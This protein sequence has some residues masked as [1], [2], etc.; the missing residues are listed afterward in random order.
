VPAD[1]LP[2]WMQPVADNQPLTIFTNALRSLTL[3]GSEALGLGHSTAYWV[4]LS[5]VWCAGILLVFSTI[6]VARFAR[7]R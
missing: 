3:G 2:G 6:A 5:F 4:M 7:L 1:S